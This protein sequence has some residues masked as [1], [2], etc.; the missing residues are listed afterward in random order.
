MKSKVNITVNGRPYEVE[1]GLTILNACREIGV[2]IPTL[3]ND[4]R[5]NPFG[6]C[7]LCRIEVVGG[8]GTLLACGAEVADGM[9]ISTETDTVREAR[10]T[11]IE[12]LLS[13]H[14]GD[15]VAPC[16]TACPAHVD[17]QGY[18][19]HIANGQY[20]EALRLI[21]ERNPLPVV[22]GRICTR[23]CEDSCRRNLVDE[24]VGIDYLKRFV[25]D[26]ELE[27]RFPAYIPEKK[28]ATGKKAAVIGAG[29]AGLSAAWYLAA[30]GHGV[31]VFERW[32]QAGGMLR[33]GIPSYRMPREALDAEIAHIERLGV[34]FKYNT[35]FG[36][37]F[38]YEDLK[39][40]GYD[41]IFLGVGS[42]LGQD[43]SCRGEDGC[44]NIY[45]GVEFMGLVGMGHAPDLTGKRVIV[46]GGGNTAVD[47]ART[48]LRLGAEN[49]TM[50]YRRTKDEMPAHRL[51]VEE[52]EREG[53]NFTYLSMP[54]SVRVSP[55]GYGIE[56]ELTRMEVGDE[57]D[58]TGRRA[59]KEIP[60]AE[61]VRYTD[62][63]IA[64]AG[65]TQDLSFIS[66]SFPVAEVKNRLVVDQELMTTNIPG[67]F[68]GGD[69][70]T[71]PQTAIK[72]I[73][74]GRLAA[75][76]M[77]LYLSG[78]ELTPEEGHYNHVKAKT[79]AEVDTSEYEK[80][81]KLPKQTM[82]MLSLEE[83]KLSFK[84]V[85]LGFSEEQAATE[86]NRCL[87]CGCKDVHECKLRE[88]ATQYGAN[89]FA[90]DGEKNI[91]PIDESHPYIIRD[92]NKC[93]M[94]GR[95]VRICSELQ[96]VGAI[97]FVSRGFD[98]AIEPTFSRPFGEEPNCV[99]C[100][101][102]V[103][104]CPVGALVEKTSLS[105]PGPFV[106]KKTDS[107]CAFCG[108]G[109][110]VE[111][112]TT[113]NKLTRT[114][115]T[116]G[117]GRSGGNLCEKGRF[118]N[119]FLN[120]DRRLTKPMR[121]SGDSWTELEMGEA[122]ELLAKEL[123]AGGKD[124][125]IYISGGATAEE[126]AYLR[127]LAG[128]LEADDLRSFGVDAA[129]ARFYNRYPELMVGGYD[130]LKSFDTFINLGADIGSAASVA[131]TIVRMGIRGGARL[132]ELE[133]IGS[134]AVSASAVSS[135]T[136][137]LFGEHPEWAA[138][139]EAAEL[140]RGSGAKIFVPS[141]GIN[142]R[143]A[144]S[145]MNLEKCSRPAETVA[146]T[147]VIFGEDPAGDGREEGVSLLERA[148]FC[149]VFDMF[150]TKTA[151]MADLVI[152]LGAFADNNGTVISQFGDI[153]SLSRA[154]DDG[155]Q[156]TDT[157][158]A[159]SDLLGFVP[160]IPDSVDIKIPAMHKSAENAPFIGA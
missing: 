76:S 70:V 143:G 21:K 64:A 111:L 79:L 123:R 98:A 116:A 60:S 147:L 1:S 145:F 160:Q 41:A 88:Y 156:N 125:A 138:I 44:P 3:C 59:V 137:F 16:S 106:E 151:E 119:D 87:S 72:A 113:G 65:Q 51:E 66:D 89:Q 42:Q 158:K 139:E 29:P 92:K 128:F 62:I 10:K 97:G 49:V 78:A 105:K 35:I 159:L 50:A 58:A 73:A 45:K 6:S 95:C 33:Y 85:E 2:E 115:S 122:L 148:G 54:R 112:C 107:I 152:P 67:V 5:L 84:E 94:C 134:V 130:E 121:R 40:E 154:F 9:V 108:E 96:G 11:C 25:A 149:A 24:R 32:P 93:I 46:I 36:V 18:I 77:D 102:C 144:A 61:H 8:K 56:L 132:I 124:T 39:N 71:G 23:P 68:A 91:H 104:T 38:S 74:A 69:V 15:C 129:S 52:A 101:Q 26:L 82:P 80:Y 57:L 75:R 110:T 34:E 99:R 55:H 135:K 14:H 126:C 131:M 140:C 37:D 12:L 146:K 83:R 4:E 153:Q 17:I 48:S 114:T 150:M 30:Q 43:L 20:A 53:V 100:G 47:A 133:G 157:L 136:C 141:G 155:I 7:L 81:E 86:A 109:C 19:A 27:G 63:I 31:T 120:D 118:K 117:K 13:Q 142:A 28:A 22:C 103:S 90:M 127:G